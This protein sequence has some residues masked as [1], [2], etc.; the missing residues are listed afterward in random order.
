[1]TTVTSIEREFFDDHLLVRIHFIIDMI[2]W[3][4]LAPCELE[5]P[6]PGSLV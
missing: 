1:M 5:F 3:T 2:W 4:D 6:F